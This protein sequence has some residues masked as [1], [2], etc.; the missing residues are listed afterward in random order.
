MAKPLGHGNGQHNIAAA[1]G[2]SNDAPS[3]APAK[4][5]DATGD[6]KF[7]DNGARL[8]RP[9]TNAATG[10]LPICWE[11]A[12]T[13]VNSTSYWD[14][15]FLE[16][17]VAMGGRQQTAFFAT[18]VF[19]ALPAKLLDDI[20]SKQFSI[21]D[22]GCALGDALPILHVRFPACALAGVDASPI[23]L[24]IARTLYP[25][26]A[27]Y[28]VDELA[29]PREPMDVVYCSNTLEHFEDWPAKLYAL[30]RIAKEYVILAV[31]FEEDA[32]ISE[33][34]VTFG[35]DTFPEQLGQA[36]QI[37]YQGVIDTAGEPDS[38]WPGRQLIVVYAH[39][40]AAERLVRLGWI[41]ARERAAARHASVHAAALARQADQVTET[42]RAAAA[43]R[44]TLE[45]EYA[46][47]L[48]EQE[49]LGASHAAALAA[50]ADQ[51]SE[52][53][54]AAAEADAARAA[55]RARHAERV[56][57]LERFAA[58]REAALQT[59]I[60]AHAERLSAQAR[61]AAEQ[62]AAA[63]AVFGDLLWRLAR[64]GFLAGEREA[65]LRARIKDLGA[66][67][68]PTAD[69]QPHHPR[70]LPRRAAAMLF[71]AGRQRAAIA[72][73]R[74][75]R[76][77]ARRKWNKAAAQYRRAVAL[78]PGAAASWAQLGQILAQQNE[79]RAAAAAFSRALALD[80][81]AA[82]IHLRLGRV[83]TSQGHFS[84]AIEAYETA[85]RLLPADD[86][87][88]AKRELDALY[89]RMV[90]EADKARDGRDWMTAG[91]LYW[92]ALDRFPGLMPIWVQLGHVLKEQSDFAGAEAAYRRALVLDGAVADTH[93]QLGHLLKLQGRRSQAVGA[94][95]TAVRLDPDLLPARE[96]LH[97]VLGYSPT[98]IERVLAG[99]AAAAAAP[100]QQDDSANPA[101][102]IAA[103]GGG[104]G[105]LPARSP[106]ADAARRHGPYFTDA[107]SHPVRQ[108]DV[109]WLSVIDW[110]YRIQRPQHLAARL[111]MS[112]SRVFYISITF[113]DEEEAGEFRIVGSP[114]DGVFEV[115][116]R[117]RTGPGVSIY[118]G[119][120]PPVVSDLQLAFD[121]LI[122]ALSIR[123][124]IVVVDH[125]SW[126]PVA[127]GIQGATVVYDC[128]DLATGFANPAKSLGDDE[129]RLIDG[130]DVIV[131]ASS[132]LA[133]H[134][135]AKRSSVVIRNAADVDFF[136]AAYSERASGGRPVIGYFGAIA[137]WF[138][139]GWIEHCAAARPDW[140][141]RLIGRTDG[142]DIGR[143]ERLG[144][145]RFYGERPYGELPDHLREFDVAIIPFKMT[146][147]IRCTNPVKLYE[148]MAAGKP[149][150]AAPMPEV[151]EATDLAYIA[152]DADSFER[153]IAQALGEDCPELRQ[154]RRAWAQQHTWQHRAA[155]LADAIDASLPWVSVIILTYN[156]WELTEPCLFSVR[157]LSDYSRLEI[158]VVDNASNDETRQKLAAIAE[159]DRRVKIILNDR[160]LG[161]AA[162]NN[163][164]LRAARGEYVILLNNDT[165]VTRGWVRDLIRPMQIDG[166]IGLVGPLTNRIGNEQRV[167][168]SYNDM[169]EMAATAR[170]LVR[171]R[172]RQTLAVPVVAF[173]CVALRRAM[174]DELGP[175]D[176]AYGIGFF[177][178]DDYC[179]QAARAN[180]KIVIADDVF[181][182]HHHS[183]SFD[184]LGAAAG[185][186]MAKNRQ[187]FESR[188]GPWRPHRYRDEPGFGEIAPPAAAGGVARIVRP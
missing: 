34:V 178:D 116:L 18:M 144:N 97:A 135:R 104:G 120:S 92:R 76:A 188:W 154:R 54:R 58:A 13:G 152:D 75:E 93:L 88:D 87:D 22:V 141:F 140:E 47:R 111:A 68:L 39:R 28:H 130:A 50:Q 139:I 55:E 17:W 100:D 82:E 166:R 133:R 63:A 78:A 125:P 131:T 159:Q 4:S 1:P 162:G 60:S 146:D 124:P 151:A 94:Y 91:Q 95:A 182:H 173:F 89:G 65:A 46:G 123:M 20:K 129:G 70:S 41:A 136:A 155:Q 56:A 157:T 112:G 21:V 145:V 64:R 84:A 113:D 187:L 72:V 177:E 184:A 161:F 29:P 5:D 85:I 148:Y 15:R 118:A 3:P 14:N 149:V 172:L 8:H 74:G 7:L 40:A 147:L 122:G 61:A 121:A 51:L 160:N 79:H 80:D 26:F 42:T 137:D 25:E 38:A 102:R 180:W 2:R 59:T 175:L 69:E 153:R 163:V 128:L 105:G 32:R 81:T 45:A 165:F 126:H 119:L 181:V 158:I 107:L 186:Q 44:A 168:I 77:V 127:F 10:E 27:F 106:P 174:I 183:A 62:H 66:A 167:A 37:V 12:V 179:M 67:L 108:Y 164:G 98:E 103:L 138:D 19:N 71:N 150:V 115:R 49:R 57:E 117:V 101:G 169:E 99:P 11:N 142:C 36:A 96:S 83:M 16:N 171:G 90:E 185:E 109:I 156:N 53:A 86:A 176:E 48:A 132:P 43:S 110:N 9:A 23:A 33:H 114:H 170:R 73:R 35:A 134:I 143:A 30:A 24:S 31:P 52:A 6:E